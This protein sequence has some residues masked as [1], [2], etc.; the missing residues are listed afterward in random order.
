[1]DQDRRVRVHCRQ[2]VQQ[3][4]GLRQVVP[5][6]F[7][8]E[9]EV[10]VAPGDH[11]RHEQIVD[12]QTEPADATGVLVLDNDEPFFP[13]LRQAGGFLSYALGVVAERLVKRESRPCCP[14]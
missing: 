7:G 1:M 6:G 3:D 9:G 12:L 8:Q 11:L 4:L 10:F 13:T 5:R 14:R 2:P